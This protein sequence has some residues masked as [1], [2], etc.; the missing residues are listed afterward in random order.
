[1]SAVTDDAAVTAP[2]T[3]TRGL[4][5]AVVSAMSF[6]LSGPF[7]S[8]LLESGWTPGSVVLVRVETTR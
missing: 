3:L 6:A 2:S 1:M 4:S 7:G 8:G 5:L